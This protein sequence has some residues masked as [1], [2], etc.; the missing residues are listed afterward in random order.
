MNKPSNY[1]SLVSLNIEG[2]KRLDAVISF[3]VKN[4]ERFPFGTIHFTWSDGGK[5]DENQR[6]DLEKT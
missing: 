1:I 5:A 2:D 3:F 6:R 4:N